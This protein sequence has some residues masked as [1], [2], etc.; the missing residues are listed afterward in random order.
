MTPDAAFGFERR[1]TPGA[2]AALGA[3]DGFD[4]VVAEP[5][6]LDGAPVSSSQIRSAIGRGDLASAERLLGRP[7]AIRGELRDR[8]VRVD[9]PMAMP[10]D[11]DYGGTIDG[12]QT[13][14]TV[15]DGVVRVAA[16]MED[17]PI[18]VELSG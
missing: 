4:L 10:P 2:V 16:P 12:R 7:V 17:G 1:G 5:F 18:R 9:L 15:H 6:L 3:V 11:G 8:T 13:S 14:V